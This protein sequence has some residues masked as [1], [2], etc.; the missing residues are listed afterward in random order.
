MATTDKNESPATAYT[1]NIDLC[2][3]GA[4]TAP[5]LITLKITR[6]SWLENKK[7][8]L[9]CIMIN[10]VNF[11]YGLDL[12]MVNGFQAMGGFLK[13]YGYQD[14][15]LPGGYGISTTMQ[16]LITSLVSA[17]MFIS[18]FAAGWITNK[19]GRKGGIWIG[20]FLMIISVTLQIAVINEGAL[21][22]GRLI[23]G[24]SNGFLIVSQQLY[25]QE[26][27]PSNLRSFSYTMYQF[28]I[29]FGSLLGVVI[30]NETAKRL[31]RS[32]YRIP[33][34][35]LYIIPV[36]L[37]FALLILPETPRHLAARGKYDEAT[38]SLR[39]L[40]DASYTDLMVEEELAEIKH[41]IETHQELSRTVGYM[42][43]FRKNDIKRTL[44][45]LGLGLYSAANGVPFV[46]QYGVYFFLLSG[47]THPFQ[48]GI[49]LMC[50]G[51]IGVMLTPFF[52]GKVGKRPIL[53]VGGIIQSLCMLGM[54]ISYTVRGIDKLSGQV[55][56]AMCSIYLFTASATTSPF[57]WQVS[58][59]IPTQRLR[60]YTLGF[61][62]SVTYLCGWS[63]TFTIP[64]FIN[65]TA[66]NWGAKYAYI[67]FGGNI[68]ISIFTFF[69]VPETNKRTLE[70][71]DE[72]YQNQ[73]P[74]RR[75]SSYE[76][77]STI[78]SRL[79]AV[80]HVKGDR[81]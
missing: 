53:M 19:I 76:C 12:G 50:V 7:G 63:I 32:S 48:S 81:N 27:M 72:C 6:D 9:I 17:G 31:D 69:V 57:S 2:T 13:D 62:S 47:D 44:T 39:F 71:I 49:I 52:T 33:L 45:S 24:L 60:S 11:E 64:Y 51:L 46:T 22:A 74:I 35:I 56:I 77:V 42:E 80:Q 28:W 54:G 26:T 38:Q 79:E 25:M 20:I 67:W 40:R 1:E 66:L 10:M 15:D 65:P 4:P 5:D 18:T 55:I 70:E 3:S 14:P 73:I 29:S 16:Q 37:T 21:Y 8:I 43:M 59:E 23:L 75:F 78:N 58:G 61:S 36:I 34:G 68:L 30:N 41:S